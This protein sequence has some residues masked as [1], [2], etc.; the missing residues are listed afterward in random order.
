MLVDK[1]LGFLDDFGK[2]DLGSGL[3]HNSVVNDCDSNPKI[4]SSFR[5]V[6]AKLWYDGGV[7]K[8]IQ[9]NA[10]KKGVSLYFLGISEKH[11]FQQLKVG[12]DFYL[13]SF[14]C[15]LISSNSC[16]KK[17]PSAHSRRVSQNRQDGVVIVICW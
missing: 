8:G 1:A 4:S 7:A 15:F 14:S 5:I 9:I 3:F 16:L 10:K 11:Y 6:D 13:T 12:I 17:I 2:A